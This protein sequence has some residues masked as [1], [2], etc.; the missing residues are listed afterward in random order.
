MPG[1]A[2]SAQSLAGLL[3]C[4]YAGITIRNFPDG[5]NLVTAETSARTAIVYGS[6]DNPNEKLV[7]LAL[8]ASALRDQG[9]TRLVLVAPYL[10]YM[11]QDKAFHSG[12][13]VS[14]R[15]IGN[16]LAGMFDR[17]V[18]VDPHLHRT[19]DIADV[20]PG[21]E[22]DALSGT[23]VL[24][25]LVRGDD[26]A[27]DMVLVGPDSESRQWVE[28]LAAAL[29]APAL[30]GAK[31]RD[32]DRNVRINIPDIE[33]VSGRIAYLADDMVSSG[34]TL[35]RS[36]ALLTEAG[37]RRVEAV[38]VHALCS[39]VDLASM[40]SAGVARLRSTDSIPHPT[41]AISLSPLLADALRKETS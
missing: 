7:N 15:V 39:P 1:S 36:A 2:D 37:A 13:A 11:R 40:Q 41:N 34:T 19:P 14:Q 5:E 9:V 33:D 30:I 16:W 8:A 27:G 35:A 18:T 20:F 38:V 23:S 28:R 3:D 31:I 17:I 4:P 32:G 29:E 22:A 21:A 24:A 25:D 12:E 6:L 26:V 10:C